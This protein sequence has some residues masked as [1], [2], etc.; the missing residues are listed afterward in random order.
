MDEQQVGLPLVPRLLD[1]PWSA[2][3]KA[4]EEIHPVLELDEFA[5]ASA[6]ATLPRWRRFEG[7]RAATIPNA[8]ERSAACRVGSRFEPQIEARNAYPDA[9]RVDG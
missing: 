7:A 3:S 2:A 1:N 9:E 8:S 6:G 5:V 4:V